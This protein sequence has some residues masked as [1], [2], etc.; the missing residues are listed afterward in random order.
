MK[1]IT[2]NIDESIEKRFRIK[3]YLEYG[4]RKGSLSKAFNEMVK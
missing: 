2:L 1:T 4:K 3:A